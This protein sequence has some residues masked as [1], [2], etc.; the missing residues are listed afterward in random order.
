M[1]VLIGG[2]MTHS[3][4]VG[5]KKSHCWFAMAFLF[6]GM[7]FLHH[8]AHASHARC[9]HCGCGVL[10]FLVGNDTFGGE[11]HSGNGGS[12]FKRYA[13]NLGGVDDACCHKVL[14]FVGTGVVSEIGFTF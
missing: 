14:V 13:C 8:A 2:L 1:A 7:F 6:G 4:S 12:V 9:W 5:D 10:F 11:E 3:V